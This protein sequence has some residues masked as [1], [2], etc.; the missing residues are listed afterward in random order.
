MLSRRRHR[1]I[2]RASIS[3]S[4]EPVTD[5]QPG[6]GKLDACLRVSGFTHT[7]S[8][9]AWAR[10]C[11]REGPRPGRRIGDAAPSDHL[12][13]RQATRPGGEQASAV[14]RPAG[15]PRHRD[16]RGCWESTSMNASTSA[17]GSSGARRASSARNSRC[18]LP[19]CSTFPQVNGPGPPATRDAGHQTSHRSSPAHATIALARC[20]LQLDDGSVRNS[21]RPS[22]EGTFRVDAPEWAS[23][24]TVD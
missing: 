7:P 21:H 17:P 6:H 10:P 22:S 8:W 23:I 9:S 20:P 2:T 12:Y 15:D 1:I 24:Y 16:R 5:G 3:G 19:S 13:L 4:D 11:D 14:L 18:T